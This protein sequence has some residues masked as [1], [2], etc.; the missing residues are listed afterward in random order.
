MWENELFAELIGEAMQTVLSEAE[1]E[2]I[3]KT[4]QCKN[5]C[6]LPG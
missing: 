5:D 2:K 6:K 1:I 3:M 4:V